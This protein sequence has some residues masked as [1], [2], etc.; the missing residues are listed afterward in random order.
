MENIGV[1]LAAVLVVATEQAAA[2]GNHAGVSAA[3]ERRALV[4]GGEIRNAGDHVGAGVVDRHACGRCVGRASR[5]PGIWKVGR[6]GPEL[7]LLDVK[8]EAVRSDLSQRGPGALPHIVRANLHDA[9]AV[10]AQHRLGMAL[11]HERRK[12]C[13]TQAPADKQSITVTHLPW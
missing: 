2:T 8:P 6:S 12:G 3:K 9:A 10:L 11:E 4:T 1:A 5:D 13:R 7:D